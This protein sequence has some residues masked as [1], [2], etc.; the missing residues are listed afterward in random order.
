MSIINKKVNFDYTIE[1]RYE[2][3]IVLFG[4]EVKAILN[5]KV[6]INNSFV[7]IKNGEVFWM[8]ALFTQEKTIDRFSD[9][10]IDRSKKLLLNKLEISRLIGKIEQKGYTL[11]PV[12]L[13]KKG[14]KYKLEIALAKGKKEHDKRDTIKSRD[15]DREISRTLKNSFK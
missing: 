14:N 13:Y 12:K 10:K 4:W 1:E 6:N 9:S 15:A 8:N 2:A 3:G 7:V 5:K 11:V